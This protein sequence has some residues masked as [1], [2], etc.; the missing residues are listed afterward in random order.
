M[1][2]RV[3]QRSQG[4]GRLHELIF[5]ESLRPDICSGQGLD[6]LGELACEAF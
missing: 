4:V 6:C 5:D 1:I 3:W 2:Y